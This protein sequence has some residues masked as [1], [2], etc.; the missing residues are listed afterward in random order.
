MGQGHQRIRKLKQNDSSEGA[1]Y[2]AVWEIKSG[3]ISTRFNHEC[4]T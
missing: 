3:N 2:R 4:V 1:R